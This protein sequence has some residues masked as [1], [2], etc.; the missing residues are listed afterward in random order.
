MSKTT[1]AANNRNP[2]RREESRAL[3]A[4]FRERLTPI[5]SSLG[6]MPTLATDHWVRPIGGGAL[7]DVGFLIDYSRK[8][9]VL[10]VEALLRIHLARLE[11]LFLSSGVEEPERSPEVARLHLSSAYAWKHDLLRCADQVDALVAEISDT[12]EYRAAAWRDSYSSYERAFQ[13]I[14]REETS[15]RS[16]N[17][18]WYKSIKKNLLQRIVQESE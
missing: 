13:S 1:V 10:R 3:A 14:D 12:L 18:A 16:D 15:G 4:L 17:A 9:Q 7:E 8:M 6:Y 5:M 11:E 2:H